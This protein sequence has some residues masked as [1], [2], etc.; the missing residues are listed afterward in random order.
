MNDRHS[1]ALKQIEE[2]YY[3]IDISIKQ[4]K[5][6]FNVHITKNG[7]TRRMKMTRNTAIR[8]FAA[9]ENEVESLCL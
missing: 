4:I 1:I 8:I 2:N 5:D 6:G 9:V 7:T 3:D